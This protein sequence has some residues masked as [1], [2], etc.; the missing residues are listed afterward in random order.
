MGIKT[1][2]LFK[3]ITRE[4]STFIHKILGV[5]CLTH[6]IYQYVCLLKYGH[7]DFMDNPYTPLL[8]LLHCCLS[9]SSFIF[10]VPLN[11]HKGAP[12]IYKEFRLHSIVFALRSIACAFCFYYKTNLLVN[13]LIVNLTM[14]LADLSTHFYKAETKTMRGMPFGKDRIR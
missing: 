4:D 13:I 5:S 7:M 3:L 14:I 8:L 1:Q 12:M 9:L 2:N 11:R 10:R 6:F